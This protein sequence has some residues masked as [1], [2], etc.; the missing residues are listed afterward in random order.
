MTSLVR[1]HTHTYKQL[2]INTS[3]CMQNPT[4]FMHWVFDPGRCSL[5]KCATIYFSILIKCLAYLATRPVNKTFD[6]QQFA[7]VGPFF[8]QFWPSFRNTHFTMPLVI[9]THITIY[10][11]IDKENRPPGGHFSHLCLC[12]AL[13]N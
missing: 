12:R 8:G 13:L 1:N 9:N 11:H 5:E 7:K 10:V 2:C 3:C 6:Q 4:Q